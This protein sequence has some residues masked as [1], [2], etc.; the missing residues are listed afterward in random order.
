[1]GKRTKYNVDKDVAKRTYDGIVF[2]SELEMKYYRDVILPQVGSGSI[3]EYDLQRCYELQPKFTY[4][5]K[6]VRPIDYVADFWIKF[7]DGRE[8]VIDTKGMP[9]AKAKLKRKMFW[10]KY[11]NVEYHWVCYSKIDGGWCKYED[12]QKARAERR[13]LKGKKEK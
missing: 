1:M 9:D 12:V 6:S 11:P 8:V 2:A 4:N 3:I 5:G 10:F 7:A 13:K